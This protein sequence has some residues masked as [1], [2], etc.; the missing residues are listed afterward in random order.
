MMNA[1]RQ[2]GTRHGVVLMASAVMP[3]MA[4]VSLVPVLPMLAREF[5]TTSGAAILVPMMLTV[6]ALCVALFSP[7]AGWLS[8]R[9]GRKRILVAALFLYGL[10]GLLPL[11]LDH[12]PLILGSRILLGVNEAAIMTV[13]TTMLGD[14]FDGKRRERWVAI[15]T[16]VTSLSAIVL[17]AV[18]GILGEAFGSRGPFM[19]YLLALPIG[20]AAAVLLFEPAATVRDASRA[21]FP[22]RAI[23]SILAITLGAALLFYTLMLQIG[24]VLEGVGVSSPAVIGGV[25]AA[26]NLGVVFGALVFRRLPAASPRLL[27][28][29]G[30]AL[31]AAG[32]IGV[33]ASSGFWSVAILTVVACIG[34]GILLPTLLTWTLHVLPPFARGR[35]TGLWTG[36]F[37]LGQFIAP[38]LSITLAGMTGGLQPV[39][40]LLGC[41][42]AV[43]AGVL[44]IVAWRGR[45]D[46]VGR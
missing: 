14:Y 35:G 9:V 32:Y 11:F 12:L 38:I 23:G 27:V 22:L 42:A 34:G 36:T 21:P 39:L 33:G 2:A 13:A 3:V 4:I 1:D 30:F 24:T 15:Q 43:A 31:S 44:A 29:S 28:A 25:G 20:I 37:F 19:L 16:A 40:T 6:P 45:M 26:A 5:S 10:I 7:I 46:S 8:D 17:I 41:L 18:G